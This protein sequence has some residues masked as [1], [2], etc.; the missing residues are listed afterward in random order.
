MSIIYSCHTLRTAPPSNLFVPKPM[1][2]TTNFPCNELV[3]E[4]GSKYFCVNKDEAAFLYQKLFRE[5]EYGQGIVKVEP[6]M[7]VLDVG[8]N[9]GMFMHWAATR[10][11]SGDMKIMAFEPAPPLY[12]VLDKNAQML[13]EQFGEK[14][15]IK[16]YPFGLSNSEVKEIDFEYYPNLTLWSSAHKDMIGD[17]VVPEA[18]DLVKMNNSEGKLDDTKLDSIQQSLSTE[19]YTTSLQRLS[20]VLRRE[21]AAG[22]MSKDQALDLVK[23]DVEGHELEVLEGIDE[24]DWGRVRQCVV[25]VHDTDGKLQAMI[26][27]LEGKGFKVR[28]ERGAPPSFLLFRHLGV[29]HKVK[30]ESSVMAHVYAVRD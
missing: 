20:D 8:G 10:A 14:C 3:V 11:G 26:D 24:S 27:L 4:D 22:T 9:I 6:G 21:E 1:S 25:E 7:T 12:Y 13:R 30:Y 17:N 29:D 2:M 15:D 18:M 16:T 28:A 5:D 19:K 23:I